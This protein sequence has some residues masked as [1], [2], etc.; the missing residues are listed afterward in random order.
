M[1][2]HAV[3]A[4]H[5]APDAEKK[6]G[7]V[8]AKKKWDPRRA[9]RPFFYPVAFGRVILRHRAWAFSFPGVAL[10]HTGH[11]ERIH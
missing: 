10:P 7:R 1:D 2:E 6:V 11:S 3:E 8:W 4:M 5:R 9:Q